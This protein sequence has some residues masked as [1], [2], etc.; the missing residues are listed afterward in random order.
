MKSVN[1]PPNSLVILN[2]PSEYAP[3][4]PNPDVIEQLG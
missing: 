2:L 4:P 3:L 1:H